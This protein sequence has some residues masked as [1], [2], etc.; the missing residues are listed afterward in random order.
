MLRLRLERDHRWRIH[1]NHC[2]KC[3]FYGCIC[4][5]RT[6]YDR[7][8]LLAKIAIL[9][10]LHFNRLV[11]GTANS[12]NSSQ[13]LSECQVDRTTASCQEEPNPNV[14]QPVA[15]SLTGRRGNIQS[16]NG[17]WLRLKTCGRQRNAHPFWHGDCF[18]SN[19]EMSA[20]P[21]RK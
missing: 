15:P 21:L 3:L 4:A 14:P 1:R 17:S 2:S 10:L 7:L 5:K 8:F 12:R 11:T 6:A 19:T 18:G 9:G 16:R 13:V 20:H